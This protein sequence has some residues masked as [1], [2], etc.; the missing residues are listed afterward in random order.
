MA[1]P[2]SVEKL[3]NA[4]R[5][6]EMRDEQLESRAPLAG[7]LRS[8]SMLEAAVLDKLDAAGD[9]LLALDIVDD[10]AVSMSSL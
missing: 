4:A 8:I 2:A 9:E 3:S 10:E 6:S 1:S 5:S 7:D